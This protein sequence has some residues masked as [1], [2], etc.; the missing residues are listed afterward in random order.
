MGHHRVSLTSHDLYFMPEN[1]HS[2]HMT[3]VYS[4]FFFKRKS[5]NIP[6]ASCTFTSVLQHLHTASDSMLYTVSSHWLPLN[7]YAVH[8]SG[9]TRHRCKTMASRSKHRHCGT[10][11]GHYRPL[12]SQFYSFLTIRSM[13]HVLKCS[14]NAQM[15][16]VQMWTINPPFTLSYL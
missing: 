12:T 16:E 5:S 8:R 9:Y 10:F 7:S 11:S 2:T 15:I 14:R 1:K 3:I 6:S 4:F 13:P